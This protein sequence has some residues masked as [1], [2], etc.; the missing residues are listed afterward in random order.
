LQDSCGIFQPGVEST[1]GQT[2]RLLVFPEEAST[3][4]R[5]LLLEIREVLLVD[6]SLRVLERPFRLR[7]ALKFRSVEPG[8]SRM[9]SR[10]KI[11][12]PDPVT[13]AIGDRWTL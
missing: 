9:N 2:L 1:R 13:L 8:E 5:V 4:F 7:S 12:L 3:L 6:Q 10:L 11:R